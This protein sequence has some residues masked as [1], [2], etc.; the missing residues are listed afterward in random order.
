VI[1]GRIQDE[2]NEPLARATVRVLR[3]QY[4]R[5]ERRLV[6]AGSDQTDDRGEYRVFG[7]PPGEYVVAAVAGAFERFARTTAGDALPP[8]SDEPLNYAP[9][10]YPGV[11]ST[12]EAGRVAVGAGQEQAGIDFSLRLVPT[13]RVRGV[14]TSPGAG[15]AVR[16]RV[17]LI[18]DDPGGALR[19]P[20][21]RAGTEADQT[22]TIE[23]V[24]PGRYVAT[25]NAGGGRDVAP[26]FAR[27]SITVSGTD[28]EGLVLTLTPGA[29]VSGVVRFEGLGAPADSTRTAGVS[30]M[31][32]DQSFS[33]AGNAS[34]NAD[35][36]FRLANIP[37]GRH[38]LRVRTPKGWA[39]KSV[40]LDGRDV[41]DEIFDVK[42]TQA[43]SGVEIVL[44]DRAAGISGVVKA[45]GDPGGTTVIVFPADSAR[46]VPQSRSIVT[47]QV[48][49]EGRYI[50]EGLTAGDYL[51]AAIEDVE[52]GEWFDPAFL[53]A[54]A[55]N[56]ER[57]SLNEGSRETKDLRL[58][59]IQ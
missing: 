51:I 27:Q 58:T 3:F 22:F 50:V 36:S 43:I 5:G 48:D 55:G 21:Y 57:I 28:I 20:G 9:T 39:V 45:A 23:S 31:A 46:W 17:M 13:A 40:T 8:E 16:A 44:S 1:T 49:G 54:I 24:P 59:T 47:T 18:P 32:F 33:G 26:L 19:A 56:A 4:Q 29:T 52:Q 30:L 34:V 10:Y 35:G 15:A 12:V 42:G 37:P 14:V 11:T 2:E 38:A 7:L 41:V 25:V 53:Q 6:P